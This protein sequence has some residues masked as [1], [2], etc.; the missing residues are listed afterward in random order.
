MSLATGMTG[1]LKSVRGREC[2]YITLMPLDLD[3]CAKEQ[4][5]LEE[6][7]AAVLLYFS[8]FSCILG[9]RCSLHGC[10]IKR[11]ENH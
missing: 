8:L 5:T 7:G 3:R 11:P 1:Q 9:K 4:T 2:S 6:E 10:K